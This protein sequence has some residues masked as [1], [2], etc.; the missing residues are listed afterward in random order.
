MGRAARTI[1]LVL[2]LALT[3]AAPAAQAQYARPAA[4]VLARARAASGG[5]A[6]NYLRGWHETGAVDGAAYERW[7]D[8]LRYGMREEIHDASG[9]VS[10]R[11]FNG[12]GAWRIDAAGQATGGGEPTLV[13]PERTDAFFGV[14][15]FFYTSRFDA[16]GRMVGARKAGGKAFDVVEVEPWG[17]TPRELWF[18]RKTGL[19]SRIVDRTGAR[20]VTTELSD[21]RK[22]G[23]LKVAFRFVSDDGA[24][25]GHAVRQVQSLDFTPPDRSMFGLPRS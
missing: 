23:P 16:R 5:N 3:A 6:W 14:Y 11:G 21:Y 13:R 12:A 4:K 7:L 10:V 25:A 2:T 8:P 19:L 9:G 17:G 15:A 22:A 1:L 24:P 20:P 18:D